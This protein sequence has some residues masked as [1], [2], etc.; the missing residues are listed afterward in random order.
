MPTRSLKKYLLHIPVQ[1]LSALIV[2][3]SPSLSLCVHPA[4]C[5]QPMAQQLRSDLRMKERNL[6]VRSLTWVF[7][8]DPWACN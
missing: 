1:W 6:T 3:W 5:C 4:L 2:F 7:D 8:P